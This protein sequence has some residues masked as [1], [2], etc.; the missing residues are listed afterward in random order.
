MTR[1]TKHL[2]RPRIDPGSS[3]NDSFQPGF[4]CLLKKTANLPVRYSCWE[5]WFSM[6]WRPQVK[7]TI[8]RKKEPLHASKEKQSA[9][10]RGWKANL[11]NKSSAN[12]PFSNICAK[13]GSKNIKYWGRWGRSLEIKNFEVITQLQNFSFICIRKT[14]CFIGARGMAQR[15]M[16]LFQRTQI[17]SQHLHGCT[18]LSQGIQYPLLL[19]L[20]TMGWN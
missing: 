6:W 3:I 16:M 4:L 1:G 10:P 17:H 15:L 12:K 11:Q 7:W 18:Y 14:K 9:N 20:L 2:A 8:Y 13:E 5:H 19:T